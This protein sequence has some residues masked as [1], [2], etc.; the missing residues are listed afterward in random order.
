M[1]GIV[2]LVIILLIISFMLF[3]KIFLILPDS[4]AFN[5]TIYE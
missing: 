4:E 5:S 2:F 3:A 1:N